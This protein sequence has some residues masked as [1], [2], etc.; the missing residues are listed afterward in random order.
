MALFSELD[1]AILL[2]VGALLLFG[3]G[4]GNTVRQL[5]R[6]YGRL[7][8]LKQELLAEF[9]QEAGLAAPGSGPAV[10]LR[11]ALFEGGPVGDRPEHIPAPV[12][13]PPGGSFA[14]VGLTASPTAAGPAGVGPDTWSFAR[15]APD[16]G[17]IR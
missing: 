6:W 14:T 7:L 8:R 4:A 17:G 13:F 1:W 10:S 5:G 16:L 15:P 2:G 12:V 11:Q 3:Q 9:T